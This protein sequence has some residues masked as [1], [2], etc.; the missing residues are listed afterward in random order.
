MTITILT[1]LLLIIISS[2]IIAIIVGPLLDYNEKGHKQKIHR[3]NRNVSMWKAK[4]KT[5]GKKNLDK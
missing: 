5:W 4:K 1:N 2:V 3:Y